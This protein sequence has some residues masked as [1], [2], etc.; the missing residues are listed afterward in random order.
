MSGSYT[1]SEPRFRLPET[2]LPL[3]PALSEKLCVIPIGLVDADRAPEIETGGDAKIGTLT[4]WTEWLDTK[5]LSTLE[6][7][8]PNTCKVTPSS[9]AIPSELLVA[10]AACLP[11]A[12]VVLACGQVLT[13]ARL[14]EVLRFPPQGRFYPRVHRW[15]GR[16][17]ILLT[18][19][20]AEP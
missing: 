7:S 2:L 13:A 12:V 5:W 8:T 4:S 9:L 16:A 6:R 11:V 18:L 19:G 17:A 10:V 20:P 1:F 15:A 3:F 14:Y